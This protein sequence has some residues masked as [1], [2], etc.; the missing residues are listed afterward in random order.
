[1][2][3]LFIHSYILN[4]TCHHG[5]SYNVHSEANEGGKKRGSHQNY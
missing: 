1:M 5:Q 4:L 2:A 3:P